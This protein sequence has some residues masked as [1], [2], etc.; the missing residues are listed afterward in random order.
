MYVYDFYDFFRKN[1]NL[2]KLTKNY[3]KLTKFKTKIVKHTQEP[4]KLQNIKIL[5]S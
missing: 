2:Q 5:F 3:E 1:L 4:E